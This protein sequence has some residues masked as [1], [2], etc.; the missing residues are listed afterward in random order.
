MTK[1]KQVRS[2]VL[3]LDGLCDHWDPYDT[4]MEWKE[5]N[6]SGKVTIFAIPQ[7]CSDT[8]LKKYRAFDWAELAVNGWWHQTHECLAWTS[9]DTVAKLKWCEAAGYTKGF[10]PTGWELTR[11][12]VKGCNE[13]E[14]WVAGHATYHRSLWEPGDRTYIFNRRRRADTWRSVHGNAGTPELDLSKVNSAEFQFARE[15]VE[16]YK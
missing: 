16:V 2:V 13:T 11:E 4:L 8:L 12:V 1:N 14:F 5:D 10:R 15:V 9:E 6:P 7:R 3:T